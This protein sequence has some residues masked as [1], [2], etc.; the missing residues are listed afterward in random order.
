MTNPS[1]YL[2]DAF[3]CDGSC[4][5]AASKWMVGASVTPW[6]QPLRAWVYQCVSTHT[7][8]DTSTCVGRNCALNG[9]ELLPNPSKSS[10]EGHGGLPGDR[11][12]GSEGQLPSSKWLKHNQ[13]GAPC[14]A[15]RVSCSV[16][17]QCC[18]SLTAPPS[19]ICATPAEISCLTPTASPSRRARITKRWSRASLKMHKAG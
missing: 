6:Y 8:P 18:S 14:N 3:A 11:V 10:R 15:D 4:Q 13:H 19:D 17:S 9:G 2:S 7:L 12:T 16:G 5:V 1:Q